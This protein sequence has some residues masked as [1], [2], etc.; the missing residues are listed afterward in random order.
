MWLGAR[1]M[2][3]SDHI[4]Q[5]TNRNIQ[6]KCQLLTVFKMTKRQGSSKLFLVE[7]SD[8]PPICDGGYQTTHKDAVRGFT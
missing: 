4:A 7:S 8:E 2:V 6:S 3:D 1:D 5:Y